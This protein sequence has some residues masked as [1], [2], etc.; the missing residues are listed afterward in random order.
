MLHFWEPATL[1]KKAQTQVFSCE[2][3]ELFNNTYFKE[4]LRTAGSK[5][6]VRGFL[7]NKV[8]SLM[9]WIPL[10]VLERDSSTGI[11]QQILC[12]FTESF[13][14]EHLL[15]TLPDV[16]IIIIIIIII[17]ADQWGLQRKINLLGEVM[18]N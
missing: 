13:F 15:A 8:A 18:V 14:V 10:A 12:S 6:L 5:T 2:F 16:F 3:C 1:L 17:F 9:A 11:F 7:F 4:H